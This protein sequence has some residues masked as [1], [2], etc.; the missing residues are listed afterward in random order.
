MCSHR[1]GFERNRQIGSYVSYFVMVNNFKYFSLLYSGCALGV[2]IVV[3]HYDLFLF[4]IQELVSAYEASI[5][6]IV[7][8]YGI[9]RVTVFAHPLIYVFKIFILLECAN[10]IFS[11][12]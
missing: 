9:I 4:G 8:Y 5:S 10:F 7:V 2:F 3:N 11:H 1:H 12:Y 6:V